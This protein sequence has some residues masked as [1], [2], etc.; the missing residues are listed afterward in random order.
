[1]RMDEETDRH[2]AFRN[3]VNSLK[4]DI[5]NHDKFKK[6]RKSEKINYLRRK[7]FFWTIGR[8]FRLSSP[9]PN[10]TLGNATVPEVNW[11]NQTLKSGEIKI[12]F[13]LLQNL[14]TARKVPSNS[15]SDCSQCP[16][17]TFYQFK[18]VKTILQNRHGSLLR[19]KFRLRFRLRLGLRLRLRFRFLNF[20]MAAL[21]PNFNRMVE[22]D[23]LTIG[24]Q[25]IEYIFDIVCTT[26]I[27]VRHQTTWMP[28]CRGLWA[29]QNN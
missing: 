26:N 19:R 10:N 16:D 11:I 3:F 14:L 21:L 27:L 18:P 7:Y 5:C 8:A 17:A 29:L 25:K 9:M 23:L 24:F 15:V 22:R 2:Y 1:M 28:K 4:K 6:N 20:F 13:F 12:C